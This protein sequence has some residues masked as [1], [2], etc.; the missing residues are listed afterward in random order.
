MKWKDGEKNTQNENKTL[1]TKSI[2]QNVC[3][4]KCWNVENN[5]KSFSNYLICPKLYE[6]KKKSLAM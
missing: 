5:T 1:L 3:I 4:Y 2:V 6:S